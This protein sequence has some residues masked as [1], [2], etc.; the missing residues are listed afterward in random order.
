MVDGH[1]W[2]APPPSEIPEVVHFSSTDIDQVHSL[3]NRFFYPTV[4]EVPEHPEGF[5]LNAAMI[6]LGPLTVGQLAFAGPV[7]LR[8]AELQAYHVS[9]PTAGHMRARHAGHEVVA[10][11]GT[12]VVF[13]PGS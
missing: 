3:L 10:T 7:T 8:V 6:Q 1:S 2:S 4:L 11:P 9:L 13:G 12:A 5:G